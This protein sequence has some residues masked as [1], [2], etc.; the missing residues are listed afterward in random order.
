MN[1]IK[2]TCLFCGE[3]ENLTELYPQTFR[4]EE[5]TPEIFSARRQTEHFHYQMVRCKNCSLVFS[6][7]IL[8]DE[9]LLQLYSQSKVTF[10]EYTDIIR[11]D[12]I[13]PL[14][15]FLSKNPG[16]SALEIGCSSGFFLEELLERGFQNVYGCEP[17]AEAKAKAS[18]RVRENIFSGFFSGGL[19][20]KNSF[21]LVCSFQTLDHLSDPLE[22]VEAC[23]D[24]LKPGGLAYFITHD[25]DGVQAKILRDKSPII[26]VEHV[27][28]FNRKTLRK[29]FERTGFETLE[30]ADMKNSYPL[31]Y[32]LKM[33][34]FPRKWKSLI[35]DLSSRSGLGSLQ[36]PFAAG[37][38]C[39]IGKC[40]KP[41][42]EFIQQT[43]QEI[44]P[45]G[46]CGEH[47]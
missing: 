20:E 15:P 30:V 47:G 23:H 46:R 3:N 17:S 28:L 26:D 8:S 31:D 13:R 21:D 37:N 2:K 25:V 18:P 33:F 11:R 4:E 6:K 39:L 14:A 29:L 45:V 16:Q 36:W 9:V 27:Y 5:L 10:D 43:A 12:Y 42:I 35:L 22:I 41:G 40:I 1:Y 24:V 34:P 32:W 38:I 44:F 7:K 19:Y